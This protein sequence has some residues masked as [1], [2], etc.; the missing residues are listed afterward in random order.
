MLFR[1]DRPYPN[2]VQSYGAEFPKALDGLK[3]GEW[4][5]TQTREGWRAMRLEAITSPKP[6]VYEQLR[7]VVMQDWT[8]LTAAEQRSASV[9]QLARKYK[10]RYEADAK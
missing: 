5:A 6:A 4:H 9:K 7:G 10:I 3:P 8:D 2:L 1:S